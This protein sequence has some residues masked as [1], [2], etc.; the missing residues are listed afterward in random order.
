MLTFLKI[1]VKNLMIV[2]REF[3]FLSWKYEKGGKKK[4]WHIYVHEFTAMTGVRPYTHVYG[5]TLLLKECLAE[6]NSMN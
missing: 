1:K 5:R 6:N 2:E 3:E 4:G